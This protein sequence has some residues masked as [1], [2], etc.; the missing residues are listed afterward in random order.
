MNSWNLLNETLTERIRFDKIPRVPIY[1][2]EGL[3]EKRKKKYYFDR[4]CRGNDHRTGY[5][6]SF[7]KSVPLITM[8]IRLVIPVPIC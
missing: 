6:F 7:V 8:R 2:N 4:C 1:R 5:R 3:Y